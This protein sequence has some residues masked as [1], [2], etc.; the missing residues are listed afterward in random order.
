MWAQY[1]ALMRADFKLF[2]EYECCRLAR[3]DF[4]ILA[5]HAVKDRRVT[6][7]HVQR[8]AAFT[9][10]AFATREVSGHHLFVMGMGEQR[11]AKEAWLSGIV[12]ELAE[13]L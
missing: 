10:G 3:F 5:F 9:S 2:D 8:W 11:S 1:V 7:Q 6:P 4:P 13:V 12:A